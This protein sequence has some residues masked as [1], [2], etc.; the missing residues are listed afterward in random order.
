[1]GQ[2]DKI[3]KF[4]E[5]FLRDTSLEVSSP[6][7]TVPLVKDTECNIRIYLGLRS[8]ITETLLNDL[9]CTYESLE[10]STIY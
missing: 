8:D 3:E 1:M 4:T 2:L 9:K 6:N 10:Q 5:K 7:F